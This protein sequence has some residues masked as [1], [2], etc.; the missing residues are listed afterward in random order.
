MDRPEIELFEK[1]MR[2]EL[3]NNWKHTME[4]VGMHQLLSYVKYLEEKA[5]GND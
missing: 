5:E 2:G 1:R 4:F 3:G